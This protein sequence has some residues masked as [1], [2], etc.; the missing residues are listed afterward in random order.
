MMGSSSPNTLL[1]HQKRQP[2]SIDW[3]RARAKGEAWEWRDG[4]YRNGKNAPFV[5]RGYRY[6]YIGT[7][8]LGY[9]LFLTSIGPSIN[10]QH[11]KW[12]KIRYFKQGE[13]AHFSSHQALH[14]EDLRLSS[15][16]QL[17]CNAPTS[18][19]TFDLLDDFLLLVSLHPRVRSIHPS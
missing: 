13:C 12:R 1:M 4:V 19:F 14:S 2:F 6:T 5:E 11:A 16:T 7:S 18:L 8:P 17:R 9:N 10:L 3:R 15:L